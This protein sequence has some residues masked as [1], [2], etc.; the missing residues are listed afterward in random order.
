MCPAA[1]QGALAMETRED[2]GPAWSL[3]KKLDDPAARAAVEAERALLTALGGGCQ[4]PIGAHALVQDGEI[5]LMAMVAAADGSRLIRGEA[6]G[7][8]AARVGEQLGA[9]L[10]AQGAREILNPAGL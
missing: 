3:V 5:R 10:L 7:R 6:V 4:V 9:T 8:D 1:G 2:G